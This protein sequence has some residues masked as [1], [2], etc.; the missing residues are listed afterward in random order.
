MN[1]KHIIQSTP[2]IR[3]IAQLLFHGRDQG[4]NSINDYTMSDN[5]DSD[6][7]SCKKRD[8]LHLIKNLLQCPVCSNSK[9]KFLSYNVFCKKCKQRFASD[10]RMYDFLTPE[11]K[12]YAG[13]R[14]TENIS[15]NEYVEIQQRL[16]DKHP[17]GFILDHGC[18]LKVEYLP[19]V[20]YFD[21]V[22]YA[23]TDVRGVVERLPFRDDSFEAVISIAVLEHVKNPSE[24]A[25]EIVRVLKPGGT[26]YVDVPF[27]QTYHGYPNHY[28]NMTMNGIKNLFQE[29]IDI[30]QSFPSHTPLKLFP[31]Y[32]KIYLSGL[33]EENQDEFLQMKI[34]DFLDE[35]NFMNKN[36]VTQLSTQANELIAYANTLIGTKKPKDSRKK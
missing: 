9:L 34:A 13:V 26:L 24:C 5:E 29:S 28:Y 6:P 7:F 22:D 2:G 16:T 33:S 30:E 21:V 1:I 14:D 19:N 11:L 20:V 12:A 27:L 23:T 4:M 8:K 18:G 10:S 25:K 36:F 3:H 15:T 32:L 35:S 31:W 17:N